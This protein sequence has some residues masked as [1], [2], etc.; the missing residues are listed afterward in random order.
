MAKKDKATDA[1]KRKQGDTIKDGDGVTWRYTSGGHWRAVDGPNKGS[2]Y[3]GKGEPGAAAT[4]AAP[5]GSVY[6]QDKTK[7]LDIAKKNLQS[8]VDNNLITQASA[9]AEYNR[10][11]TLS[12]DELL[13]GN[14]KF[15]ADN[16]NY[17]PTLAGSNLQAPDI[18]TND[19]ESVAKG[20]TFYNDRNLL[21]NIVANRP[22]EINP[23]GSSQYRYDE[24][25]GQI[26]RVSE[27]S[28]IEKAKYEGL[29]ALD[30][31]K[32]NTAGGLT[33]RIADAL[34]SPL[35]YDGLP[36]APTNE[37]LQ[38]GRQRV[39]D[40]LFNSYKRRMDP[41]RSQEREGL[42]QSL[43]SRGIGF[44]SDPNSRYQQE[45]KSFEQKWNDAYADANT[46]A[47]AQGADEQQRQY[48]LGS[49]LRNDAYAERQNA[50]NNAF[51]D[52]NNVL[53]AG[54]QVAVNTPNFQ[55]MTP[56]VG[57]ATDLSSLASGYRGQD[58]SLKQTQIGADA[59]LGAA[60]MSAEATKAAAAAAAEASKYGAD[61]D[62]QAVQDQIAANQAMQPD[63][64]DV[65]GQIG[66]QFIGGLAGGAA[67]SYM[68]RSAPV[69]QTPTP[70]PATAAPVTTQTP[71]TSP[72]PMLGRS[73]FGS[74]QNGTSG[75]FNNRSAKGLF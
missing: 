34:A 27:L 41:L 19:P 56:V 42:A 10:L 30:Q 4:P 20:Q 71:T 2:L 45:M 63:S 73:L 3:S 9:D 25:T 16:P 53:G 23:Y 48:T 13:Q 32:I 61:R 29:G 35:N 55:A 51:L 47:M 69:A 5:A 43:I 33:N 66:G 7:Q 26:T 40:D 60:G 58:V 6:D 54:G 59:Q 75:I 38:Q 68:Q 74:S 39:E 21:Q 37:T 64:S 50:R 49:S 14:N 36:N 72:R 28:D 15:K 65:W 70:A 62:Y 11:T 12:A 52:Y 31:F 24:K 57:Q 46:Q 8:Q 22:N 67:S 1:T 44:S 17:N 18:D